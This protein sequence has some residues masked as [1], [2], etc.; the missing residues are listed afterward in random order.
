MLMVSEKINH[1]CFSHTHTHTRTPELYEW[2]QARPWKLIQY[3]HA[4]HVSDPRHALCVVASQQISQVDQF[5]PV[6][7]WEN[8]KKNKKKNKNEVERVRE[9]KPSAFCRVSLLTAHSSSPTAVSDMCNM[10]SSDSAGLLYL[11]IISTPHSLI[12]AR[13]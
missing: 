3:L 1:N 7:T 9:V 11:Y 13:K 4:C 2:L 10:N 6:Q 8:G 5:C 12:V